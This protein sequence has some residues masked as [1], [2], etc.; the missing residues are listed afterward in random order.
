M[1]E[2]YTR[3]ATIRQVLERTRRLNEDSELYEKLR[4][5]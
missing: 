3:L 2:G 1:R 4:S 5:E